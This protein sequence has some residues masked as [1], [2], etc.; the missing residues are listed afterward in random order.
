M[1]KEDEI[2]MSPLEIH[3]TAQAIIDIEAR[4]CY[5]DEVC[6]GDDALRARVEAMLDIESMTDE[7]LPGE[8]RLKRG[9]AAMQLAIRRRLITPRRGE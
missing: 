6:K 3:D 5:L 1:I 9:L 7:D 4:R 8:E 2:A